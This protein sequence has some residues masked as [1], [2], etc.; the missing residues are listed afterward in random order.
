MIATLP[1]P[2]R[3][4]S[5]ESCG[6]RG[7]DIICFGH[8]WT[9]DPL[10]K[11]HVMRVLSREN[12]VLWVNSIGYRRPALNKA[13][14]GRIFR[15]LASFTKRMREVESNIFVMNPVAVPG[16]SSPL[17]RRFNQKL[18]SW[19][20]RSAMSRLGFRDALNW[21]CNPAAAV[22]AGTLGE[23]SVVY[24]CVDQYSAIGG[25]DTQELDKLEKELISRADTVFVSSAELLKTKS[26]LNAKTALIRHGVDFDHFRKALDPAT[27]VPEEI[28]SLPRP[29]IGYFGLIS[30]DWFDTSLVAA[31]AKRFS[32]G[33]VVLLGKVTNDLSVLEVLP[34]VKILGR[35]PYADL[36]AYCK[37]FD[38]SL[39]PFPIS[40]LTLNSN[41]LKAREYLAA[42]LPVV[43]TEI[44]EVEALGTCRTAR[45]HQG[46]F[47]EI[48]AALA[49][50][51]PS[52]SR[53]ESVREESWLARVNTMA[54]H[55]R[56]F[57][58][59][60]ENGSP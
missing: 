14:A 10:S 3:I 29:I 34:N 44:P 1:A 56:R 4:E 58:V 28:R 39:I 9:G 45:D 7:R 6:I 11:T 48:E 5:V 12:R 27:V 41:P 54:G 51:G 8:D 49:D 22:V 38:V 16:F 31:V 21:V 19:Q 24:Y 53:S 59:L 52:H 60:N 40:R 2:E 33:T 35:Q 25:I 18:L 42:G 13:D 32:Q 15:K 26:P 55:L 50:P 37:G 46:F 57:G 43:S 20:V 30:D 36:P 17:V 47:S 23:E